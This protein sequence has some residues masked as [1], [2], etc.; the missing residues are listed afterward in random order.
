[1]IIVRTLRRDIAK[2]NKMD[3][4]V[5]SSMSR[6][7]AF[8]DVVVVLS[9]ISIV[10]VAC[11][12]QCIKHSRFL[13]LE[14][15]AMEETGWKLVHG[16]VFRPPRNPRLFVSLIGSGV[17]IFCCTGIVIGKWESRTSV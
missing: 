7:P 15:D 1:M 17:Q 10:V 12:T 4:E 14:D 6:V 11:Q 5:N 3:E 16:D 2:Y 13:L 9:Q 8:L